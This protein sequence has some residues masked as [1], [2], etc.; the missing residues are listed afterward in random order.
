MSET[1][2]RAFKAVLLLRSEDTYPH[3]FRSLRAI[4][5]P[6]ILSGPRDGNVEE[7]QLFWT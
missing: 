7:L 4:N 5:Y 2:K 1:G 6:Q 3:W